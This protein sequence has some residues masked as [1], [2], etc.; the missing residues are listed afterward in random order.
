MAKDLKIDLR[1]LRTATHT[2]SASKYPDSIKLGDKHI[3]PALILFD[4]DS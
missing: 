1:Y 3:V 4:C 2:E